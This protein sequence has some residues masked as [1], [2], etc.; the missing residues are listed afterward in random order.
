MS[1]NTFGRVFRLTTFGESHGPGLGGVVDG[2]PAGIALDE[3]VI[4]HEL[5]RRKPGQGL[6]TTSRSESDRVRI[7]SGVYQG[8]TTGTSI[9]FSIPNEDQRSRDYGRLETV[10]RPG[11]ADFTYQ[12]KYGIRDHRGGGRSSGR[13]TVCRVA[14][15]A[16]AGALLATMGI[17][18]TAYTVELGGIAAGSVDMEAAANR[19]FFAANRDVVPLW[20]ER[21]KAVRDA[22]DTLGGVVEIVARGVPAGLGEPVLDKLDARLA[23]A[24]MG[25][26]AIKGVEIGSGFQAARMLGSEN[27]DP[28]LAQGFASNNAGGILGGISTGQTVLIRAS[29][30]PIPSIAKPQTTIDTQGREQELRIGGRHDI[31]AIPR[32]VPVLKAMV[33]LTL[34]DMLLLQRMQQHP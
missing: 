17:A 6:G 22:S 33:C 3:D 32:I 4:Q 14:G 15:G 11:H 30:K 13:E 24:L 29:V 1:G 34:A 5:D 18:V 21:I 8:R 28:I 31:C 23:F 26:G 20:E 12:A 10:Y 19:P 9:G 2:C 27:N 16:I 25:V 7:L